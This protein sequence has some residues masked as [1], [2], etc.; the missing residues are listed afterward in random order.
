MLFRSIDTSKESLATNGY[1]QLPKIQNSV[2]WQRAFKTDSIPSG[3]S[4]DYIVRGYKSDNSID[5]LGSLTFVSDS[6]D[7]S[8]IDAKIYPKIDFA[9]QF[10]ANESFESPK[11]KSLGCNFIPPPELGTNYQ[12]VSSTADTVLIGED[13]GLQFYVYNVG[14]SA[15]DSFNVKVEIINED[16]SRNTIFE[17]TVDSLGSE[18]RKLFNVTYNT[19]SGTGEKTFLINIDSDNKITELYE[20][21]NFY[22]VPFYIKPDTSRPSLEITFN[23]NDILNGEYISSNPEI[24]IELND[25]T[26]LPINDTSAVTIFLNDV[27]VYYASN[28]NI[29]TYEFNSENP[30][31]VVTYKPVLEDGDYYLTVFGKNSLD[32]IADSSGLE[33]HFLVSNE[34]KLLYVYNYPNPTS[35]E[36][37][38]T[39]KLTQIPDEIRIRIFTIAGRLIKEID[40]PSTDLRYDFNKIYWDGRD[41]DGDILANGVYLYKVILTAGTKQEGITQKLAI[42]R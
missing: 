6:A 23:G 7:L 20:D 30:K 5:T 25:E 41:A 31:A 4:L 29:L 42:V 22:T 9:V 14:E 27:P 17:Q 39:F 26:L 32:N 38:F 10:T 35:G 24:R 19:S 8:F 40:V 12:V 16:N 34:A 11:F 18:Q 2:E 28:P 33:K 37:Y 13:V 36:T 21:N 1:L 3:A 15:A